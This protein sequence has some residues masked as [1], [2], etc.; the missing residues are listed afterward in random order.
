MSCEH[1][2]EMLL[3]DYHDGRL[4]ARKRRDIDLHLA[5]CA[6]CRLL[7]ERV[8]SQA[9]K[10]FNGVQAAMPNDFCWSQIKRRIAQEPVPVVRKF[11]W[12]MRPA[13][14]SVSLCMMFV[15]AGM[16]FYQTKT[17]QTPYMTYVLAGDANNSDEVSRNIEEYFL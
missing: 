13:L 11:A 12:M 3:T 1:I 10:P 2:R 7:S 9:V 8:Y 16:V 17:N 4:S 15:V 14:V 5:G 6:D